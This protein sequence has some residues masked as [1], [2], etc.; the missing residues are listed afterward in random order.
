MRAIVRDK[1]GG[2]DVLRLEEI[3]TPTPADN[4]V[5]VKVHAAAVN[6]GDWEILRGSPL[7]VRLVGFGLTKPKTRILGSNFAGSV[8]AVGQKVSQFEVGDELCGD[9]LSSGL[10]A[11]AEYVCVPED[12]AIVRKPANI[13]FEEA[14]SVPEAGLIALQAIRDRGHVKSG[15][16][17]LINGAGGGA[18]TFAIQYAKL[19]GAEVTGIDNAEKLDLMRSLGADHVVDY[20]Q[21]DFAERGTQ[22]DLILDVV[23]VRSIA[24]W[25]RALAPSGIYV[26]AGGSVPQICKTLLLGAWISRRTTKKI[27]VLGVKFNKE[28]LVTVIELLESGKVA[29]TIDRCYPLQDV[30]KAIQYLGAGHSKGKLV[31]VPATSHSPT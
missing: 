26:S 4:E 29:A 9:I 10:G 16:K 24:T 21:E 31:I 7:W 23:G 25:K 15:Q 20:R 2:P 3:P 5:L 14:A 8:E 30:P 18:G 28:D 6:K 27:G 22:Y 11:F 19:V 12:A 13:T 17:V 1:Y